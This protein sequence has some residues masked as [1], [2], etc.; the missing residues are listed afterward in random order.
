MSAS[1]E[2]CVALARTLS[3][4]VIAVDGIAAAEACLRLKCGM[5]W[6]EESL[7]AVR[8]DYEAAVLRWLQVRGLRIY[9]DDVLASL[10]GSGLAP[11]ECVSHTTGSLGVLS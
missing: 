6:Q 10:R 4:L 1:L 11:T 5:L 2:Y 8:E 7:A 9:S 3:T